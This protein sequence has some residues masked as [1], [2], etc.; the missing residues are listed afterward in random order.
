[1]SLALAAAAGIVAGIIT[2]VLFT[3]TDTGLLFL[4]T[5]AST[6]GGTWHH[7]RF[8]CPGCHHR[9]HIGRDMYGVTRCTT[10]APP[11]RED[12]R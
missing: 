2:G 1:M 9:F 7:T 4:N 6:Q 12:H 3:V 5:W 11:P 10:C 8:K